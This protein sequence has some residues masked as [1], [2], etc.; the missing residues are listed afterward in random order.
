ME[1]KTKG[2]EIR[3]NIILQ[4]PKEKKNFFHNFFHFV[5]EILAL[6]FWVYVFL[7]LFVF[8]VD[9]FLVNK[10]LPSYSWVLEFKFIILTTTVAVTWLI[11]RSKYILFWF[12]YIIFYP[13]II[14]FWKIPYFIFRQKSWLL[15]F[16]IINSIV[17]LFKSIKYNFIVFTL[18]LASS[19]LIF[20]SSSEKLLW[21][22][23]L[24]SFTILL[25]VFVRRFI[26]IFKPSSIFQVYKKI[27]S[28][29][30]GYGKK[31]TDL[32]SL[33]ENIK[34][35]PITDLNKEQ[36]EK[37]NSNLQTAV[38]F[39]R[40]CLFTA[41]KLKDYQNSGFNTASYVLTILFLVAITVFSFS[42]VNFGLFKINTEF[43]SYPITP[44]F[45]TFFYYSFNNLVFNSIKEITPIVPVT[46]TAFMLE[47]FLAL[48]LVA[49]FISLLFSVKSQKY[50]EELNETIKGIESQGTEV[51]SFIKDEYKINSI[52]DAMAE[53]RKLET[54]LVKFIYKITE[55]IK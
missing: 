32:F 9:L 33:E 44:S 27:F 17:S 1:N 19:T 25:V 39:N 40:V 55:V 10:Y 35:L 37:R 22:A 2:T 45:F 8:D 6:A 38:L 23:I 14:L 13:A 47:S 7:K 21:L 18:F 12:L 54:T 26:S 5:K 43:F 28:T 34:N 3:K 46:Q 24:V 36:L 41:K 16:S 48:I 49:I 53:L 29:I 42:V 50:T 51:E 52:E 15:A 11:T 20:V 31:R 4:Q 30:D